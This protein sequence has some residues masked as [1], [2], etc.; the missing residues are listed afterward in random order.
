MGVSA[1]GGQGRDD[2]EGIPAGTGWTGHETFFIVARTTCQQASSAKLVR[3]RFPHLLQESG[4]LR[5]KDEQGNER[6]IRGNE[7]LI[8]SEKAERV[9]GW[10]EVGYPWDG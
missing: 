9:L 1:R 4:R 10:K 7:A 2:Q 5:F 8:S 6:G 3:E